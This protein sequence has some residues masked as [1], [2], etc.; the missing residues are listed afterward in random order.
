[1]VHDEAMQTCE[2][3]QSSGELQ[4]GEAGCFLSSS[5]SLPH[6]GPDIGDTAVNGQ[7]DVF[8]HGTFG[9]TWE[10]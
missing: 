7:T 9:L 1:M 2:P 10:T 3:D 6:Y 5:G 4:K 8:S